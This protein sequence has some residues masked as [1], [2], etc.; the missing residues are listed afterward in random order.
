MKSQLNNRDLENID[1][2]NDSG[3]LFTILVE[4]NKKLI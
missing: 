1:K 3:K 2:I 4:A